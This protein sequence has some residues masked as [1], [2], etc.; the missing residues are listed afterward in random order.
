MCG[1]V[2]TKHKD[3]AV[4]TGLHTDTVKLLGKRESVGEMDETLV[5]YSLI[6]DS[7]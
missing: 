6:S 2:Q 7:V 5:Q 3:A 1:Y 4:T